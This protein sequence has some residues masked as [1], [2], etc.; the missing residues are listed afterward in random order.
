MAR[1]A[2]VGAVAVVVAVAAALALVLLLVVND[3]APAPAPHMLNRSERKSGTVELD[4]TRPH[5][6]RLP[7]YYSTMDE[8]MTEVRRLA[9]TCPPLV[10]DSLPLTGDDPLV[11]LRL[12]DAD[13]ASSLPP[14]A[15][16]MDRSCY[17]QGRANKDA[18]LDALPTV[19]ITAGLHP[20][21]VFATELALGLVRWLCAAYDQA[22]AMD[23]AEAWSVQYMLARMELV[24]IPL[25]NPSGRRVVEETDACARTSAAG[26]DLN[27][28]WVFRHGK[29]EPNEAAGNK[30]LSAEE[31]RV[32]FDYMS[33]LTK[34]PERNVGLFV[35]IHSGVTEVY[36]PYDSASD[37]LPRSKRAMCLYEVV[38]TFATLGC[39]A[40][41]RGSAGV[42]GNELVFG[43]AADTMFVTL[44]VSVVLTVDAFGAPDKSD[45]FLR[46]NPDDEAKYHSIVAHWLDA[47]D[48]AFWDVLESSQGTSKRAAAAYYYDF[49]DSSLAW[50]SNLRMAALSAAAT[51][52]PSNWYLRSRERSEHSSGAAAK[53]PS[54]PSP[55]PTISNAAHFETVESQH[56]SWLAF[57]SSSIQT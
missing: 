33:V 5:P 40:C 50:G 41:A 9:T 7:A 36:I 35:D 18:G 38:D 34:D 23:A 3:D 6:M 29:G 12:H 49:V 53:E 1:A 52:R 42:I 43:T 37:V 17:T 45:C 27:R 21:E 11:V 24:V 10:V 8:T 20:R 47:F 30:P 13:L 22:S 55:P 48:F 44:G 16:P 15:A 51:R 28:N 19:L 31:T 39:G 54:P 26:I 2:V 25:A 14:R 32:L 4:T 46:F 57:T 56:T